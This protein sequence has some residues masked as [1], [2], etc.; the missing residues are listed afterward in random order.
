MFSP[1]ES[2]LQD[3]RSQRYYLHE[4]LLAQLAGNGA[5][6]TGTA[7]R[8][9]LV[10]DHCCIIVEANVRA[11]SSLVFFGGANHHSAYH[12][13]LLNGA[14]GARGLHR[15]NNNVAHRSIF[16][17]GAAHHANAEDF[18]GS[19]VVCHSQAAFLLNHFFPLGGTMKAEL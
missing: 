17:S 13:A 1:F 7:R 15:S 9:V 2:L 14:A 3:L 5:E 12:F 10:Y 19:C 18:L 4:L 8:V 11:I 16:T 6:D